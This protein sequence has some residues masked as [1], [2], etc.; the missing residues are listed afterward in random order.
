MIT[1]SSNKFENFLHCNHYSRDYETYNNVM[2]H[3]QVTVSVVCT[4][5][6]VVSPQRWVP[7]EK[8]TVPQL[9]QEH[10]A[11]YDT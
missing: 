7:H 10:P 3:P 11:F 4:V 9:V 8:L 6:H 5:L 2:L 1:N